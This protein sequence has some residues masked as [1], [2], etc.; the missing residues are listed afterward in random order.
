MD[1]SKEANKIYTKKL[2]SKSPKYVLPDK[3]N[4]IYLCVRKRKICIYNLNDSMSKSKELRSVVSNIRKS[5][6]HI[7][8]YN[9][10]IKLQKI[11]HS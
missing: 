6:C 9:A 7:A 11:K 8:R 4:T 10:A 2:F 5:Q 1:R 3:I